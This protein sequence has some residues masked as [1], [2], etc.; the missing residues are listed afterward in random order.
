MVLNS[1]EVR[2][3]YDPELANKLEFRNQRWVSRFRTR[4]L[5]WERNSLAEFFFWNPSSHFSFRYSGTVLILYYHIKF[6]RSG[7]SRDEISLTAE[8]RDEGE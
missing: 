2:A 5:F 7:H 6:D 1:N 3:L 8:T 4:E